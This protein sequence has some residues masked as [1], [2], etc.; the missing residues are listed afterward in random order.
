MSQARDGAPPIRA[1]RRDDAAALKAVIDATFLFPG[2]MLDA[3]LAPYFDG[4]ATEDVWLTCDDGA[5]VAVAY[6]APER[7]TSGTRNLLLI[8]VHP[9]RQGRGLGAALMAHVEAQ[10]VAAGARVLLVETSGLPAFA[11]TRAFY[12][13]LG[14][15]EEARIRDFYAAGEDKVV[16]RRAFGPAPLHAGPPSSDGMG[17]MPWSR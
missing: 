9:E 8:A 13:G 14:Y 16:F 7:M 2:E 4:V 12:A 11:R 1:V 3:M 5:P 17:Q 6:H 10:L 15:E